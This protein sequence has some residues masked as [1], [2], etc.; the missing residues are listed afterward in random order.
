MK[1]II[2]MIMSQIA[3]ANS[4]PRNVEQIVKKDLERKL[5][6]DDSV[7]NFEIQQVLYIDMDRNAEYYFFT[8]WKQELKN[9]KIEYCQSDVYA[10]DYKRS[11]FLISYDKIACY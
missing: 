4:F 6:A 5:T 3:F 11:E 10:T 1:T 9:G 2:L 8:K 7:V